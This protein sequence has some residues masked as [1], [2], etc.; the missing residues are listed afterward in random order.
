MLCVQCCGCRDERLPRQIIG[1]IIEVLGRK[2]RRMNGGKSEVRLG[3]DLLF[4][5]LYWCPPE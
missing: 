3:D 1:R 4:N 2:R 5:Q